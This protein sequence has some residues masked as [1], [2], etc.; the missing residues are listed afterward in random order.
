MRTLRKNLRLPTWDYSTPGYYFI[1]ICT[2][3]KAHLFGRCVVGSLH[4]ASSIYLSRYGT[5]VDNVIKQIP[6]HFSHIGIDK[7]VIMPNHLHL[8]LTIADSEGVDWALHEAPLRRK[9]STVSK[10]VGYLKATASKE[11]HRNFCICEPIWQRG[12]YDHI[13]RNEPDYLRIWE[14]VDTNPQKWEQDCY[15]NKEL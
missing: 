1:T 6:N 4:E 7:Y 13:I 3:K 11:I 10:V 12:Y 14:Y 9:R 8:I 5:I 15:Y 2:A